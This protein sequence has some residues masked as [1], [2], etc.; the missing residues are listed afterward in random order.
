L[1]FGE[2]H[3]MLEDGAGGEAGVSYPAD[4]YCPSLPS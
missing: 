1:G 4:A 3:S 2:L